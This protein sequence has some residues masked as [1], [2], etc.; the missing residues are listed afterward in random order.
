M[1]KKNTTIGFYD[2]HAAQYAA[3]TLPANMSPLC[4]EFLSLLPGRGAGAILDLGCGSGRDSRFFIGRGYRVISVDGSAELCRLAA[5]NIGQ[6]V[7]C[8]DFRE[9]EPREPLAGIWASASLVH[10][11]A[12]EIGGVVSRIAGPL[13]SGGCFYMSFKYGTF[14][15]ER[16]GRFYTDMDETSLK[17]L[18]DSIPSLSLTRQKITEDVRPGHSGEKWLNAFFSAA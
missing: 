16:D 13:V 17:K 5:A 12:E 18:M 1:K 11:M 9:Y 3:E 10:L 6:P 14:S 8:C 4:D 15:G 2:Q 7:L